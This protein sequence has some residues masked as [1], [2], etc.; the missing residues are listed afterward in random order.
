MDPIGSQPTNGGQEVLRRRE[1]RPGALIR[2]QW[3]R[4]RADHVP[5]G[6]TLHLLDIENLMGGPRAG[7]SALSRALTCY[8]AVMPP[9][10][11]VDHVVIGVNPAF[12][13][14]LHLAKAERDF[15]SGAQVVT[16]PGPDGADLALLRWVDDTKGIAGRYDRVVI[17]SGDGIFEPLAHRFVFF[18]VAVG[19]VSRESSLSR[20]LRRIASFA[21]LLPEEL[22]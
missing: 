22:S 20:D 7:S 15:W 19:V 8:E 13:S 17:G 3:N 14:D 18:G 11:G 5:A 2:R 16:R 12:G 10:S 21:K 1:V 6:R 9:V 4:Q